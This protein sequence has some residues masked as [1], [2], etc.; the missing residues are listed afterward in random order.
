MVGLFV[1]GGGTAGH[2]G[3][4]GGIDER[5]GGGFDGLGGGACDFVVGFVT[6]MTY[7]W[8]EQEIMAHIQ[9][10]HSMVYLLKLS[11]FSSYSN[12]DP[13]NTIGFRAAFVGI[14]GEFDAGGRSVS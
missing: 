4:G 13:N 5:D 9:M 6:V 12:C 10:D 8:L 14:H 3:R 7:L 11:T 2:T 1:G